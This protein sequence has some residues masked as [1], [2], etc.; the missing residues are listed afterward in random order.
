MSRYRRDSYGESISEKYRISKI[1]N[2]KKRKQTKAMYK[3]L[4]DGKISKKEARKLGKKG[5]SERKLERYDLKRYKRGSKQGRTVRQD[6]GDR[7]VGYVPFLKQKIKTKKSKPKAKATSKPTK[8]YTA[9]KASSKYAKQIASLTKQLKNQKS[10]FDKA[11]TK[12][13]KDFGSQMKN[14]NQLLINKQNQADKAAQ[15][16]QANLDN[17]MKQQQADALAQQQA[18]QQQAKQDAL[19]R[20]TAIANQMRAA[21]ASPQL[22]LGGSETDAFGTGAFKRRGDL[23]SSI[24]QGIST[25]QTQNVLGGINV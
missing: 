23:I 22:R 17:M 19:A 8:T 16:A 24:V 9:P 10:A 2:K 4:R 21:S 7:S 18:A 15:A 1:K 5:I 13:Q 25:G 11:Y 14:F 12:Q 20:R 3:A 6:R